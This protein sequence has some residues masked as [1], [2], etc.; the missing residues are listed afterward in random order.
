MI[1]NAFDV[2]VYLMNIAGIYNPLDNAFK[3]LGFEYGLNILIALLEI[4]IL[5][6]FVLVT[7]MFLTWMERK[8]VAMVQ[9]RYGPMVVGPHGLMQPIVD[10]VKLVGKEDIIPKNA[11]RW[12]FTLAPLLYLS[13]GYLYSF[14]SHLGDP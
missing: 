11:D 2:I 7:V 12:I 14:R 8:V 13:Q 9:A 5:L 4:I 6:I 1:S 3:N 10:G